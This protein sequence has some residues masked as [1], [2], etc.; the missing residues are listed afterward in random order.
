MTQIDSEQILALA[1]VFEQRAERALEA[2]RYIRAGRLTRDS[3]A[4]VAG[5]SAYERAAREL[6]ALLDA[7]TNAKDLPT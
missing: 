1:L 6:R 7:A 2:V 3:I 5:G 4:H